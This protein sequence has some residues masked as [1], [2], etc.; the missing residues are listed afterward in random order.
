MIELL[1]KIPL[2]KTDHFYLRTK[3][4]EINQIHITFKKRAGIILALHLLPHAL[5]GVDVLHCP[6]FLESPDSWSITGYSPNQTVLILA[7][8]KAIF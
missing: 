6:V 7:I 4:F 2:L 5:V 8:G 1:N 3:I